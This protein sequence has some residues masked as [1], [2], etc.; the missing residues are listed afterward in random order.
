LRF[1]SASPVAFDQRESG[2]LRRSL[3]EGAVFGFAAD[4]RFLGFRNL[5]FAAKRA[6]K[7]PW[8]AGTSPAMTP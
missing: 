1:T 5:V 2:F 8:M 6:A 4:N 7:A 3:T